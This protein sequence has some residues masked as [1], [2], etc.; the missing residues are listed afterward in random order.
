MRFSLHIAFIAA[1][2]SVSVAYA[3]RMSFVNVSTEL[4]IPSMECY[5]VLQDKAGY[6]LISTEEGLC[7]Y[8]G[9]YSRMLNSR[10]G[11]SSEAVY[12]VT[13]LPDG[14]LLL[15]TSHNRILR[16]TG[17]SLEETPVSRKYR[18]I[19]TRLSILYV[20]TIDPSGILYA[21]SSSGMRSI[22]LRKGHFTKIDVPD[23]ELHLMTLGDQFLVLGNRFKRVQDKNVRLLLH[24]NGVTREAKVPHPAGTDPSV[25]VIQTSIGGTNFF[26]IDNMLIKVDPQRKIS[27]YPL[28]DR[29]LSLYADPQD[30]LW[31][32]MLNAGLSYY[33]DINRMDDVHRELEELSVTCVFED[34]EKGLWCTTLEQGV[35]YCKN[36]TVMH[37]SGSQGLGKAPFMLKNASGRIFAA[38]ATNE[39][40]E[41]TPSGLVHRPFVTGENMVLSDIIGYNGGW[42]LAGVPTVISMDANFGSPKMLGKKSHSKMA[43]S[44][45]LYGPGGRLFGCYFNAVAEIKGNIVDMPV[46]RSPSII[47]CAL[48][49]GGNSFLLGCRDG[50]YRAA[51]PRW[52][53]RKMVDSISYPVTQI[54]RG[55]DGRIWV[56][57]R[58]GLYILKDGSSL[59]V[60]KAMQIPVNIFYDITQD[61]YGT[62]WA[63]A[64]KGLVKIFLNGGRPEYRLY[65]EANGLLSGNVEKVAAD[66]RN[67]Y[68]GTSQGLCFF[69]LREE[70]INTTP[71]RI[72]VGRMEV[73]GKSVDPAKRLAFLPDHNSVR[74]ILDV[75]TFKGEGHLLYKIKGN[76]K[77]SLE[78][79]TGN[80]IFLENLSPDNYELTVYAENADGVRSTVPVQLRFT[81]Q[82]PFWQTLWFISVC[83]AIFLS[84]A[85]F[86]YRWSVKRIRRKT[87]EKARIEQVISESRLTALQ[88]QMDPHFIFNAINSIQNYI[89][90]K[91]EKDAYNYLAKFSKLI[92]MVLSN[93]QQRILPLAR[94]LETIRLY[95]ELEQL[96]CE[97]SFQFRLHVD[98]EIN[99]Y[100]VF[101]PTML[102]Q[103]YIENAIWHGLMNLEGEREGILSLRFTRQEGGL[104]IEVEDNGVGRERTQSFKK[105]IFHRSVGSTLAEQR[106]LVISTMDEYRDSKVS[107]TDLYDENRVSCGT[108]VEIWIQTAITKT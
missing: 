18:N 64:N 20:L 81:I 53:E 54:I 99:T 47:D 5:H 35:F 21:Q 107:V 62:I 11:R 51:Y 10:Q 66:D 44:R 80:E 98:P 83:V 63:G 104:K 32:G 89:L 40:L 73:S 93:S 56:T 94:E 90:K 105:D 92:R 15:G 3:Q 100:K 38:V 29:I 69:P 42:L 46:S 106:L 79:T 43:L 88:A 97:G 17:D 34:K 65:S 14:T 68:A 70:L 102:I 50:L 36:K 52:D 95:V 39:L 58:G 49:E 7:R 78:R 19:N 67:I 13:T 37:Y 26:N 8:N 76:G 77:D 84:G 86:L 9:T 82:K 87:E 24:E 55:R 57:A 85:F 4:G 59:R 6:I 25:R 108:R 1:W 48:Y 75:L 2:M 30:G 103:P 91:K 12:A 61:R 16:Y 71:P 27:V 28:P 31:V 96:R 33:R 60:D 74:V 45:L 23:H 41:I 101:L 72:H 22:D